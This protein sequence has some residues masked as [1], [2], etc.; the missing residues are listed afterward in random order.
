M[1]LLVLGIETS[2]DETGVALYH[3]SRGLLSNQ[4]YSQI[5][6]HQTYGGVVPELASRDHLRIIR[7]LSEKA[8]EQIK[9][10]SLGWQDI[11]AIA[12][13]QGPGLI[14][15]LLVGACFAKA[16]SF[17]TQ[18]PAIGIHHLEG[19]LVSAMLDKNPP[20]FPFLALLV[21]GG[22]TMLI[23]AKAL[24]NYKIIGQT[25]DDAA[26]EAFDKIA[27]M[28]GLPYPG[29]PALAKLAE[30]GQARFTLPRPMLN[31]PNLDF[32][33]SGLKTA[34][35][36][37]IQKLPQPLSLE[38]KADI[39]YAAQAAIVEILLKKTF[40]ALS[41]TQAEQLVIVGGV[42]ANQHLRTEIEQFKAQHPQPLSIYFPAPQFCTDNG[43]MIAMA[44][45]MRLKTFGPS[46]LDTSFAVKPYAQ[47]QNF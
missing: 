29:G 42:S 34:A 2:C 46:C 10:A 36:N 30:N 32:S 35:F 20:Q 9:Q 44:G 16:L 38:T 25:L 4:L 3:E 15:A 8:I 39:A 47:S 18:I 22:H 17:A 41:K 6:L 19:H 12:Y 7:A 33:F 21:S 1:S 11:N 14:G 37:L 13:T 31:K 40:R 24:G 28:L 27:K 45:F 5:A 23:E 43:A 26:G